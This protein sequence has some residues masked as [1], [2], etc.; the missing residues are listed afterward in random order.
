MGI[1]LTK[2]SSD[3][4]QVSS[5]GRINL[6]GEHT[7]YNDGFV[8]PAAIDKRI[9]MRLSKN[10]T[11]TT[12]RIKSRGFDSV[13]V[14]DLFSLKP[15]TEGWHNYVL[16]VLNELQ[17]LTQG[18][19]G[20]DCE[21]YTEVP[22]GSGVSSSAALEC[23]LAYGLNELFELGLNKWQL[24]KLSQRAEHNFVGTKC[25]IMDQFSSVMG[26]KDHA[27]LLDCQ[28]L[29]F[30][31]IPTKLNP[32]VI[33][34]L[35]TNVTHNLST[36]GYNTRREESASGL[37]IITDHFG[38]KN[39]FREINMEMVEECRELLGDVRYRRCSYILEENQRVLKA[40]KALKKND[41]L[42]L[43]ELLYRSHKG[44][45]EKYEV[46][47]PE[48]DFLVEFSKGTKEILGS[49]MVGGGFGGCTLNLINKDAVVD[50]VERASI[51]YEKKFKIKLS[52]FVTV[53][54]QGTSITKQTYDEFKFG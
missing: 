39:S 23:G 46:S 15:G 48:L 42:E 16:G 21:M 10:G 33:L 8:L 19:K 12:C 30:E 24:I 36:S 4:I 11:K 37:K 47:C 28:S 53:P 41:L 31:Y 51:A 27:M 50:Y 49:R 32:Y 38:V 22:A 44:Q 54:S 1:T 7:D 2:E 43:G 6:I 5:P 13:L 52:H 3:V 17:L 20:F 35:N 14:A 29:D 18:L 45:S 40:A 34:M 25:G 9:Y 26:K